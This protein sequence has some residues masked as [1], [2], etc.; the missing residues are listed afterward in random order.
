MSGW[1]IDELQAVTGSDLL[2][3]RGK[4]DF[5]FDGILCSPTRGQCCPIGLPD[6]CLAVEGAGVVIL[7]QVGA[8]R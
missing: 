7:E 3:E 1:R 2:L 5:G 8:P 4:G 6:P